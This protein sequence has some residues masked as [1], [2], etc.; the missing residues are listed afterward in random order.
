MRI[1][2]TV[3][4]VTLSRLHPSFRGSRLKVVVPIDWNEM[5]S[6]DPASLSV[7]AKGEGLVAWD[8]LGAGIGQLVALAEGPEA[9]QPFRPEPKAVDAY[10]TALIDTIDLD[11]NL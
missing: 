1:A 11:P 7:E 10:V 9:S 5:L 6:V 3:G 4:T 8:D 2:K